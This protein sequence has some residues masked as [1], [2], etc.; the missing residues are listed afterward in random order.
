[1]FLIIVD[2][3]SKWIEAIPT[4]SATS[5]TTIE[6]LKSTFARFGLPDLV[7]SDNGQCFVSEE[8]KSF[9]SSNGIKQLTSAPYRP[10]SNGLAE[11]AVQIVKRGLKKNT[12]GSLSSRLAKTLL[13][14]RT[15]PHSTTGVAPA[16]VML[17]QKFV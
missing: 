16:K 3:C 5:A 13:S 14:Y 6:I 11:R 2:A 12:S 17:G 15:T 10:S 7:V 9:L 8:F 4:S 1:M